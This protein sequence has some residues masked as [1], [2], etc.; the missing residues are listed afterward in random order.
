LCCPGFLVYITKVKRK[1]I[2]PIPVLIALGVIV[3][4]GLVRWRQLDFLESLERMTYDIR[5]REALRHS[6]VVATNLGFV[7]I[8]DASIAC[9]QTN[10][11]LGYEYDFP[12]PRH[13]YGRLIEELVT[14][15][16][17]AIA[18][19]VIFAELRPDDRPVRMAD[20][21][22]L[23][24]DQFLALQM[25][26]ARRVILAE[27]QKLTP[28][29]LFR[30]NALAL[31]DI[32]THKDSPDGVLR[33]ALAFRVCR[34]WHFAF[35]QVEA[36]PGYGVDL[37]QAR[38]EP[39]RVVLLRR[40]GQ[41][42]PP[43][44]LDKDGNFNLA[45]F[46]GEKLPPGVPPK[47]KPFTEERRLWH[48]GIVLAAQE[49]GLDLDK[50]EIDLRAGRITLRGPGGVERVIP[51]DPEGYFYIDWALPPNNRQLTQ[52]PMQS[53]LWQ[54]HL[55]LQ[56]RTNELQSLWQGKLV[57]VGSSATGNN[58]SDQGATPLEEHTL[59]VSQHWNVANSIITGRFIHRAPLAVELALIGLLGI[60]AAL[61]TWRLRV[62]VA[63][64]AVAL[65]V[66][67]YIILGFVLYVQ[68][69]YWLP[70]VL[71][72]AGS[73]VMTHVSLVTWRVVFEQAERRRV[74]S[75]F[76]R[77]VSPK[78]VNEL[79]A[80]ET[81]SLG[82]ARRE[83]TVFFADVR[84]FTELTDASQE[85]AADFVRQNKLEGEAA[86]TYFDAQAKETLSTVNLYLGVVADTVIRHD[87]T[88]DKFIGDCVMAFWG[89]PTPNPKHALACVRAAIEAQRAIYQLNQQ[90]STEN[91]KREHENLTRVSAGLPLAPP[92]PILLL[93]SGINT[94]MAT[95]GLMG[96]A[97]EIQNYTVFGREVNLASR[98]ES[99]SG[100]G[101]IFIGQTTYEHLRRDDPAL[102]ATCVELPPRDLK[103]FR[104]AVKAYEVPW[105]P[106]GALA[107]EEELSDAATADATS[108][109]GFIQRGG[110]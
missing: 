57:V 62:L 78:I 109:T 69:R 28:P 48:M 91:K 73:L 5:V 31:G 1:P 99:A 23:G 71:P 13:V 34:K 42:I 44:L 88:L 79:L 59:L 16:A 25:Q 108:V 15:G 40:R 17:R 76:S 65:L 72:V 68:T 43:V 20:G 98:L 22:V 92:L 107:L 3:L 53:V 61:V 97:A 2:T 95:V 11:S 75:I 50:A 70:L 86:E 36:D 39:D 51:V 77:I 102:A 104:A 56:G 54:D 81:L 52:E 8:D 80:A 37:D 82:G 64:V 18:L 4:V 83:V 33:R 101:R 32:S 93:G 35:R 106:Q 67:A 19:D 38:V 45:D 41:S 85:R 94:G 84:G 12:W 96:S 24:S 21:S 100:R 7:C 89:A 30:T 63:S 90:R 27:P 9:V 49:L 87:G 60:V 110:G 46:Y 105:R 47:A 10:Q 103:G 58:L 55:R 6:P 29:S 14:Q 66:A 26:C 74:K